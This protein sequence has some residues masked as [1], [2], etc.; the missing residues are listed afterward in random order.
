MILN[1][2]TALTKIFKIYDQVAKK[3]V[4]KTK[5]EADPETRDYGAMDNDMVYEEDL[6]RQFRVNTGANKSDSKLLR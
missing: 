5:T 4:T 1:V 3:S 2:V 6:Y